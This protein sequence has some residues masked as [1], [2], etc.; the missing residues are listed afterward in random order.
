MER[1][2]E[3]RD[4]WGARV[5]PFRMSSSERQAVREILGTSAWRYERRKGYVRPMRHLPDGQRCAVA[6]L[7]ECG[8][9]SCGNFRLGKYSAVRPSFLDFCVSHIKRE[10]PS[11]VLRDGIVYASLGSGQLLFDWLLLERLA[12][13]EGIRVRSV[14]LID[15][16]YGGAKRRDAS[17]DALRVFASWFFDQ[18]RWEIRSFL[19]AADFQDWALRRGTPAHV[20]LDCDAVGA[21][22]HLDVNAF[23]L[24]AMR[25]GGLCL[26]LSNPAK[27]KAIIRRPSSKSASG[28]G[29][30]TLEEHVYR[31]GAWWHPADVS[32]SRSRSRRRKRSRRRRRR[33][34]GS[35]SGSEPPP[36]KRPKL[37]SDEDR[38]PGSIPV[39]SRPRLR[40]R[41]REQCG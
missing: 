11:D 30:K 21:R 7:G 34:S 16:D 35:A 13:A 32:C 19:S 40:S 37:A 12:L 15:K 2:A 23:R 36:A 10:L 6:S 9:R 22:K 27:R 33:P 26:V 39:S 41:R 4:C 20:V 5:R 29:L 8:D 24:A 38:G 3:D 25:P 18:G 1:G 17:V 31:R 28:G 14:F